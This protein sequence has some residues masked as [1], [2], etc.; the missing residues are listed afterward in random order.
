ML[1]TSMHLQMDGMLRSPQC[2]GNNAGTLSQ[3]AQAGLGVMASGFNERTF[4]GQEFPTSKCN[5]R[6]LKR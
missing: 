1:S 5:I 4:H 2:S 3:G 6:F